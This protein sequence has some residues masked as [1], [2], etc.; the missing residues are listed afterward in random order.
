MNKYELPKVLHHGTKEKHIRDIAKEGLKPGGVTK[1]R[2]HVHLVAEIKSEHERQPGLR[3]GS[4]FTVTVDTRIPEVVAMQFY[5]SKGG[6]YLTRSTI[7][8]EWLKGIYDL[9]TGADL[10]YLLPKPT[11]KRGLSEE[12]SERRVRLCKAAEQTNSEQED[13]EGTIWRAGRNSTP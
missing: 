2:R 7:K 9:R 8:A 13:R 6:V 3:N 12:R 1:T 10:S 11:K 5:R 4:R